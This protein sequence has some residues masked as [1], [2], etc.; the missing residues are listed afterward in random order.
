M[1]DHTEVPIVDVEN[2][3]MTEKRF[4]EAFSST[5]FADAAVEFLESYDSEKPFL[6]LPGVYRAP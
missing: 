5:L 1:S 3:E 6:R 4:G 2:G